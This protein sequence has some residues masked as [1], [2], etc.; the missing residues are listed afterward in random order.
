MIFCPDMVND[1]SDGLD[2][3][4]DNDIGDVFGVKK[5]ILLKNIIAMSKSEDILFI[6]TSLLSL[7]TDYIS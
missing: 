6:S 4:G 3:S 5:I 1:R 7:R 2:I